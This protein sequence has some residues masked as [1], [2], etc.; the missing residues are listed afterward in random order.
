RL[1]AMHGN[2]ITVNYNTAAGS[3]AATS[4]Y[5]AASG[6][7]TFARNEQTKYIPVSVNGDRALEADEY[8]RVNLSAPKGAKVADG[9][10]YV[11]IGDDEPYVY[12]SDAYG[13]E[14]NEGTTPAEFTIFMNRPY[15]VPVTVNYATADGS[16]VAGLDY[17]ATAGTLT[18]A[19]G[20]T[21]QP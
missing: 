1:S 4:D 12:I 14:G 3:A 5:S 6:K 2:T 15:D 21:S 20:E 13:M 18:F 7:L 11:T 17:T 10:G 16:A 8:F 9:A 19:P